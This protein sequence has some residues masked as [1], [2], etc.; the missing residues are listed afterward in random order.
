LVVSLTALPIDAGLADPS[1]AIGF[2]TTAPVPEPSA[3]VLSL[4]VVGLLGLKL[5]RRKQA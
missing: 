2:N 4:T 5:R 3:I 1:V